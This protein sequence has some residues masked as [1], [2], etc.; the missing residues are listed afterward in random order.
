MMSIT[1]L[2]AGRFGLRLSEARAEI[3]SIAA[4]GINGCPFTSNAA[5]IDFNQ[6]KQCLCIS[7]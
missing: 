6:T 5:G 1:V 3:I 4:E 7:G 2:V